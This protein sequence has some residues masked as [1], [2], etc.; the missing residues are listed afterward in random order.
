[1]AR[2]VIATAVS[3]ILL[4]L[5]FAG[6]GESKYVEVPN[7]LGMDS[8]EAWQMLTSLGLKADPKVT[9]AVVIGQK[10]VA[11]SQAKSGYTIQLE[12]L[13]LLG[14]A[15]AE[16][17]AE[18]ARIAEEAAAEEA[19]IVAEAEAAEQAIKDE[20]AYFNGRKGE[21]DFTDSS[22]YS[23]HVVYDLN[24]K[25]S[26]DTT[27]GAPGQ[28]GLILE[29]AGSSCSITNTTP[30]KTV[31]VQALPTI[32][33]RLIFNVDEGKDRFKSKTA[34]VR[35]FYGSHAL[36]GHAVSIFPDME[37]GVTYSSDPNSAPPS[38]DAGFQVEFGPEKRGTTMKYVVSEENYI[39]LSN[40]IGVMIYSDRSA[41]TDILGGHDHII[42]LSPSLQ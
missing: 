8:L 22:G 20:E 31:P 27:M 15:E 6:C 28:T 17:E 4:A 38:F 32:D 37:S 19:R 7:V 12:V 11:G 23:Y 16:A 41:S 3:V 30:G 26:E 9:G 10:P 18:E 21:F 5:M 42:Y 33:A 14:I 24:Y 13:D 39:A 36:D 25:I 2:K 40:P 34:T 35:L 29:V 1:M